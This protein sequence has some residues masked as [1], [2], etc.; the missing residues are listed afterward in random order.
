M[1]DLLDPLALVELIFVTY[2]AVAVLGDKVPVPEDE[3]LPTKDSKF[4]KT[5]DKCLSIRQ[6]HEKYFIL[7]IYV[8]LLCGAEVKYTPF[9]RDWFSVVCIL[10]SFYLE[11]FCRF[12]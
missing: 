3:V 10:F 11:I 5:C 4:C 8:H 7:S 6:L 12:V 2:T 1:I 9:I